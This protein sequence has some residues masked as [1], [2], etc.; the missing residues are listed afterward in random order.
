[1]ATYR[2]VME[3]SQYEVREVEAE[4]AFDAM[5]EANAGHGAVV[6]WYVAPDATWRAIESELVE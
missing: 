6:D 2:V 5:I 4:S 1:M 3:T